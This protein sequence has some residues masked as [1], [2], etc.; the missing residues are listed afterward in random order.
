MMA[1]RGRSRSQAVETQSGPLIDHLSFVCLRERTPTL[2]A[3][4][5]WWDMQASLLR[6]RSDLE[7]RASYVP[8]APGPHGSR[9]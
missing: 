3:A 8:S 5:A 9:R 1:S 7:G 2:S 6:R 4:T